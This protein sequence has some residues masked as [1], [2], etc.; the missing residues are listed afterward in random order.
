MSFPDVSEYLATEL[1]SPLVQ[2]DAQLRLWILDAKG[3]VDLEVNVT[4]ARRVYEEVRDLARK[5]G[6]KAPEARASGELGIIAFMEAVQ[7]TRSNY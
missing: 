3:A 4:F 6:D 1:D 7:E 2:S 5:L